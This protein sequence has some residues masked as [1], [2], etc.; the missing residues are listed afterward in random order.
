MRTTLTLDE[1]VAAKLKAEARKSGRPFKQ[2]V[3]E[4]LREGLA[5][6]KAAAKI[7]PFKVEARNLG[8]RPGLSYDNIGLLLEQV[9]GPFHK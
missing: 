2:V 4:A 5:K 8:L 1:D 9:E 7:P 3:N 6:P